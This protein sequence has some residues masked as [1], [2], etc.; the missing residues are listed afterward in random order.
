MRILGIDPGLTRTGWGVITAEGSR[1]AHCAN[2]VIAPKGETMAARLA[3]LAHELEKVIIAQKPDT[4]AVE[5][6]FVSKDS[7]GSLK[8]GQARAIALLIPAQAGLEVGEYAP[9]KI[10]KTL[11]GAGH[12]DKS[13]IAYMLKI[14]LPGAT[15]KGADAAD[16]LAVAI[17]HAWHMQSARAMRLGAIA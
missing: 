13:Q 15:P 8:L 9:N 17:C 4:A 7:A 2:G 11:T 16:A 10:K 14:H 1:L 6:T 3:H 12:A 5:E